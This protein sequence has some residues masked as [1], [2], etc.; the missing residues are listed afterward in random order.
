MFGRYSTEELVHILKGRVGVST[1]AEPVLKL[2]ANKVASTSGDARKALDMLSDVIKK[3]MDSISEP[4]LLET[5]SG[6]IVVMKHLQ[7]V[8]R[9]QTKALPVVVASLPQAAKSVLCVVTALLQGK[10]KKITVANLK[11]FAFQ[12]LS[13]QGIRIDSE[14]F[15]GL[16]QTLQDE[17]LLSTEGTNFNKLSHSE[18]LSHPICLGM[19]LE[20]VAKAVEDELCKSTFF[21][22]IRKMVEKN[23]GSL[24]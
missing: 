16:L 23:G 18:L 22:S 24:D 19:Q 1:I 2:V 17:G 20:D 7:L 6:P 3:C 5:E 10:A 12:C 15:I 14:D 9:E 8:L 13:S 21:D 11:R 4:V